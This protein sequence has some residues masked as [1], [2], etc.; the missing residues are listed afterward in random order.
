MDKSGKEM[1]RKS[2]VTL[3]KESA[4]MSCVWNAANWLGQYSKILE[5][6]RPVTSVR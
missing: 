3:K 1:P 6:L 2:K 5:N 4:A